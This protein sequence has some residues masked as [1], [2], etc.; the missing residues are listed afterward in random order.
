MRSLYRESLRDDISDGWGTDA[1][2]GSPARGEGSVYETRGPRYDGKTDHFFNE[3]G[4]MNDPHGHVV[5]GRDSTAEQRTYD[6]VRDADG[7][8][9]IDRRDEE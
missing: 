2:V 6:Y 7:N 1:S 9:Y 3:S 8:V 5:E 4:D